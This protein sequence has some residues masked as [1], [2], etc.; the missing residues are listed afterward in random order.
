VFREFWHQARSDAFMPP[1]H[2][3]RLRHA[4]SS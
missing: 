4:K 2:V 1:A 3:A